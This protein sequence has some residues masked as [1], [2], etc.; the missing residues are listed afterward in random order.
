LSG[1]PL[2]SGLRL[3]HRREETQHAECSVSG[4]A[5][6]VLQRELPQG[7]QKIAAALS[8]QVL[9]LRHLYY[10]L[11]DGVAV[12]DAVESFDKINFTAR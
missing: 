4:S 8:P 6:L 11:P 10:R 1:L 12:K 5:L 3:P 9:I 2:S 7:F